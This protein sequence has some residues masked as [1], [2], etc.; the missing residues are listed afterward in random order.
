MQYN[1]HVFL[2]G[3]LYGS[4]NSSAM[5]RDMTMAIVKKV[6][7]RNATAQELKRP[8]SF[9]L[10]GFETRPGKVN[11][12][13]VGGE[14]FSSPSTTCSL[15]VTETLNSTS[16]SSSSCFSFLKE[17]AIFLT[18]E[19][20]PHVC[21]HVK[22]ACLL[23]PR[24]RGL[25]NKI[26]ME[27]PICSVC[28]A[29]SSP[30]WRRAEEGKVVCLD[31]YTN[32]KKVEKAVEG[33]TDTPTPPPFSSSPAPTTTRKR[34]GGRRGPKGGGSASEKSSSSQ[35]PQVSNQ[36]QGRR[37]LLKGKVRKSIF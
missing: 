37:T 18:C 2:L 29:D 31:C 16:S 33:S 10:R 26:K 23:L 7:A 1:L 30:I 28:E 34:K 14:C 13:F 3:G 9:P 12:L 22:E 6:M 21:A 32:H 25:S 20:H 19:P 35:P 8:Q 11:F 15:S 17:I 4:D 27:D 5:K 24:R 36:Q